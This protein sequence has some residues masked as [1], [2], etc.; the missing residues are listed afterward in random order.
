MWR[1]YFVILLV[2]F[3]IRAEV[4]AQSGRPDFTKTGGMPPEAAM[5]SDS[6]TKPPLKF[7]YYN[8][9]NLYE[10]NYD[11]DT[12]IH[13]VHLT[14]PY[15]Q[16][17][18]IGGTL[19]PDLSAGYD[20][21]YQN[22][23]EG[24]RLGNEVHPIL[25]NLK[26][27][28]FVKTNR[29][30]F[31]VNYGTAQ[32]LQPDNIQAIRG[33]DFS[34]EFY[35]SFAQNIL[36]NF[37]Y[38]SHNDRR[39]TSDQDVRFKQLS[40]NLL[41]TS[42]SGNRKSFIIYDNPRYS[43]VYLRVFDDATTGIGAIQNARRKLVFGNSFIFRDSTNTTS[44]LPRWD[45]Q[46]EF[47]KEAYRVA[48]ASISGQEALL[49]PYSNDGASLSS[50]DF[51]NDISTVSLSNSYHAEFLGGEAMVGLDLQQYS[52][53]G[54]DT[55]GTSLY[56]IILKGGYMKKVNA[57]MNYSISG[58]VGVA[59]A[60][61]DAGI[62][63]N[64]N[65]STNK[66]DLSAGVT[67]E[68][69]LPTL[70]QRG[71]FLND[72]SA[73]EIAYDFNPASHIG[74]SASITVPDRRTSINF[75]L[76]QYTDLVLPGLDGNF[77]QEARS[78]RILGL[79][80]RTKLTLGPF[81]TEHRVVYQK[82]DNPKLVRPELQYFG[83]LYFELNL[84][85]KRMQSQWGIDAYFTPSF[86]IPTFWPILG[87]FGYNSEA[88]QSGR[89]LIVNPYLNLQVDKFYFFVKTTNVMDLLQPNKENWVD[90]YPFSGNRV[91]FGLRWRLLD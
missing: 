88:P 36:L 4:Y 3:G 50:I 56:P 76:N 7:E 87:D 85:K 64:S 49:Y 21:R 31:V 39:N 59:E 81:H 80:A 91:R 15:Y 48:D 10:T 18:F 63:L 35:K 77:E 68:R 19:G 38:Q 29:P 79:E 71:I 54:L 37:S 52:W 8:L 11:I 51:N 58:R 13:H 84:F 27:T 46:L 34:M 75:T 65:Y 1:E 33:D 62:K 72:T 22:P 55:L 20:F 23:S 60:S 43:D 26:E 12:T 86:E 89:M 53:S 66:L 47:G 57:K 28:R 32:S 42:K 73:Q 41:Q 44:I 24:L 83:K 16:Q 74:V 25:H 14:D 5:E 78:T 90:G 17:D 67:V 70:S 82:I 40:L 69:I 2:V 45:S 6:V 9:S 61:G 30:Y